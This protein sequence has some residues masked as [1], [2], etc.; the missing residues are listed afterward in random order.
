MM[1]SLEEWTYCGEYT[2][3][4][5]MTEDEDEVKRVV[6]FVDSKGSEDL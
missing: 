1:R 5:S 4:L 3:M 6:E 2:S